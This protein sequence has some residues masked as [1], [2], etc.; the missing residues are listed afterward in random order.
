VPTK[1]SSEH[2]GEEPVALRHKV[3]KNARTWPEEGG[4]G[5][6]NL[7]DQLRINPSERNKK[8]GGR[9]QTECPVFMKSKGL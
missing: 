3:S 8:K 1:V 7:R 6:K 2:P 4:G 9:N 5:K